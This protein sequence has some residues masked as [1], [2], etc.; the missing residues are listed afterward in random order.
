MTLLF[1]RV[2]AT[3][4]G[5]ESETTLPLRAHA[6]GLALIRDQ[7]PSRVSIEDADAESPTVT[8]A[9]IEGAFIASRAIVAH[10]LAATE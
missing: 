3:R 4:A 2:P 9:T 10:V 1:Y 6:G 7:H 5:T 8:L